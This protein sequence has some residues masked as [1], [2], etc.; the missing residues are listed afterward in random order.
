MSRKC[1][2]GFEKLTIVQNAVL[3]SLIEGPLE[4]S[5]RT[6]LLLARLVKTLLQM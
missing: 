3:A 4:E 6:D 5:A 2:G 1:R